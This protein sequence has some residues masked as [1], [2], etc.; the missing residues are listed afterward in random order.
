[1]N[2]RVPALLRRKSPPPGG[3]GGG[4]VS[5]LPTTDLV[6]DLDS[7]YGLTLD[8]SDVQAWADQ[9]GEGN[10][11]AAATGEEPT[12]NASAGPGGLPAIVSGAGVRMTIGTDLTSVSGPLTVYWV[13]DVTSIGTR[14]T[15]LHGG[16]RI[17]LAE[18]SGD[19]GWFSGAFRATGTATVTGDQCDTW[20]LQSS[21]GEAWVER[22]SA[23]TAVY[24]ETGITAVVG[25][26][27]RPTSTPANMLFGAS[28]RI[29]VYAAA[30]DAAERAA[31][32]DH[33]HDTYGVAAP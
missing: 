11:A 13:G 29:L 21:G 16:G 17:V 27:S 19:I 12:Y 10:D 20:V 7:R 32:W 33:I 2:R 26:F 1:M 8:G 22:A 4:G 6:L 24:S 25:L 31:V 15:I 30:H 14:Q 28:S 9:S 18:T 5:P 23:G 3:G